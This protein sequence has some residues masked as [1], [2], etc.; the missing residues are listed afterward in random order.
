MT[1]AVIL[2]HYKNYPSLEISDIFKLLHQSTFGCEHM[3]SSPEYALLRIEDEAKSLRA[4]TSPK[5]DVLDGDFSRVHLSNLNSGL[6]PKTLTALFCLSSKKKQGS[7]RELEDKLDSVKGLIFCGKLPFDIKE[8]ENAR[9]K[10]REQKYAPIHHSD[11]YRTLYNPAYRVISNEY[12]PFLP[13][14]AKIDSMLAQDRIILAIDGGAASGKSTLGALLQE[15]YGCSIFHMD[16]FFL[17]PEQ[18]TKE[19]FAEIGGNVDRERFYNEVLIPLS[20]NEV[21]HYRPFD[22]GTFTLKDPIEVSPTPLSVIEGSYSMHPELSCRYDLSVFLDISPELQK[23]RIEIRNGKEL[24]DRFFSEWI[25]LENRYFEGFDIKS[26][27]DI[28]IKVK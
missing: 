21:V 13:L 2:D 10:W 17:R 24:A 27:C 11:N 20:K 15:I 25:P 5:L 26:K 19:R 6:S 7:I 9:A 22:C 28:V 16:D 18:R 8:F 14:F 1:K 4:E 12:I 23:K 3:V